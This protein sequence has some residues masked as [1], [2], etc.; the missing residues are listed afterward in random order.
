MLTVTVL[1]RPRPEVLDAALDAERGS[2][3]A[4]EYP[5]Y[6]MLRL[7]VVDPAPYPGTEVA[8]W[9]FTY[10]RGGRTTHVL[11]RWVT[12]SGG[13]TYVLRWTAPDESWQQDA[14]QRE[15]V[16]RSFVPGG[17]SAGS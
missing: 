2:V 5:G 16:F 9:E 7:N 11:A 3:D 15:A 14:A 4:G 13:A 6:R 17:G 1:A 10:T 8:D 12:V